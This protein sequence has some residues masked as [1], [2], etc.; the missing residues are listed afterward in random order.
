MILNE[1]EL[2]KLMKYSYEEAGVEEALNAL[3]DITGIKPVLVNEIPKYD[4]KSPIPP[5]VLKTTRQ[6]ILEDAIQC[7]TKDRNSTRGNPKDNFTIISELW[8]IYLLS[9]Y[10]IGERLVSNTDVAV[11]MILMKVS[12]IITSPEHSDHWT[13]IAGYSACGGEIACKKDE[14]F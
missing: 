6:Q 5:E 11:M 1:K 13:D 9:K 10:K 2:S 7:V 4:A 14:S 3:E 8:N 12:R